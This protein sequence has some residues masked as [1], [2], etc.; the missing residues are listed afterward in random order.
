VLLIERSAG[1]LDH[2]SALSFRLATEADI[3]ALLELR[4][5][6]DAD[7][8]ERFG[9]DRYATKISEKSVVL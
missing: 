5:A 7:Q 8:A 2:V 1:P 6:I 3:Q 9:N 4:L